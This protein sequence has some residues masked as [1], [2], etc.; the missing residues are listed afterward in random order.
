MTHYD[1][2]KDN[3]IRFKLY[4]ITQDVL[5]QPDSNYV[6]FRSV[7]AQ[8][9]II[10]QGTKLTNFF[11]NFETN[12]IKGIFKRYAEVEL[13]FLY[14][15]S[16]EI[17]NADILDQTYANETTTDRNFRNL[18]SAELKDHVT[19]ELVPPALKLSRQKKR[20]H[21]YSTSVK[22]T[23][24]FDAIIPQIDLNSIQKIDI[25]FD[26]FIE[27]LCKR[28]SKEILHDLNIY[29]NFE[30]VLHIDITEHDDDDFDDFD[31]FDEP[32]DGSSEKH[33]KFYHWEI[34]VAFLIPAVFILGAFR[35]YL[36]RITTRQKA[37]L[38]HDVE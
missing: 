29:P 7:T 16:A 15:P 11:S 14:P 12:M 6:G 9:E 19:F 27:G 24:Q 18:P 22:F 17:I 36:K 35:I 30:H 2:I 33:P 13:D 4:N 10:F 32:G 1:N 21:K 23:F 3:A 31:D 34:L 37:K 28:R 20:T 25:D 8:I 38:S 5:S 26:S